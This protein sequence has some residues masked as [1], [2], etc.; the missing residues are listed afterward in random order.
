M[1]SSIFETLYIL[2]LFLTTNLVCCAMLTRES[3]FMQNSGTDSRKLSGRSQWYNYPFCW[4]GYLASQSLSSVCPGVTDYQTGMCTNRC[5]N[6]SM[7]SSSRPPCIFRPLRSADDFA[8]YQGCTEVCGLYMDNLP[9]F[10]PVL[11][12]VFKNLTFIRGVLS[13]TNN[14]YLYSLDFLSAVTRAS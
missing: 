4:R 13:I 8:Y 9:N 11:F 7:C 1:L 12:N 10:D 6:Y 2:I 5:Q 14:R 3:G